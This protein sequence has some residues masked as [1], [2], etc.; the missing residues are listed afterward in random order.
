M[1]LKTIQLTNFKNYS[2]SYFEFADKVNAIV[3]GKMEAEKQIF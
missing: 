1:Y 3:K 2:D